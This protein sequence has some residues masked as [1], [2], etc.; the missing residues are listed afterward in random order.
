MKAL[1]YILTFGFVHCISSSGKER[2]DQVSEFYKKSTSR[3]WNYGQLLLSHVDKESRRM[4]EQDLASSA[5]EYWYLLQ[6]GEVLRNSDIEF[7]I[8]WLM[9]DGS[10]RKEIVSDPLEK[11]RRRISDRRK[12][13]KEEYLDLVTKFTKWVLELP[14]K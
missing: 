11:G 5:F 13:D 6:K 9:R 10:I 3:S 8:G 14:K 2:I 4:I 12:F 1:F 7:Y